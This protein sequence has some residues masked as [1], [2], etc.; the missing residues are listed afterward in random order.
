MKT[1]D[2]KAAEL[3][4]K[5]FRELPDVEATPQGKARGKSKA[6]LKPKA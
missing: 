1:R 4:E 2:A 3:V 6:L 5:G